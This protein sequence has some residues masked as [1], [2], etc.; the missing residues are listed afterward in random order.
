LTRSD[1]CCVWRSIPIHSS[2]TIGICGWFWTCWTFGEW[3]FHN[4][5]NTNTNIC[6]SWQCW[7]W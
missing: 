2:S 5:P 6:S 7:C 1:E 4:Y 3:T